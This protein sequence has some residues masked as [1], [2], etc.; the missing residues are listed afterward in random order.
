MISIRERKIENAWEH[1]FKLSPSSTNIVAFNNRGYIL[2]KDPI[3][4]HLVK[5]ECHEYNLAVIGYNIKKATLN[6]F[7]KKYE[8]DH[9]IIRRPQDIGIKAGDS[10]NGRVYD[11]NKKRLHTIYPGTLIPVED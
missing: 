5:Q 8:G 11:V 10:I 4:I 1:K 7:L 9:W 3:G 2:L 6:R